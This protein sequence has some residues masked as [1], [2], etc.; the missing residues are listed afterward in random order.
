MNLPLG[1]TLLSL[2]YKASLGWL[3]WTWASNFKRCKL[4]LMK[5]SQ[6]CKPHLKFAGISTVRK[7]VEKVQKK[8]LNTKENAYIFQNWFLWA[9]YI[10][11]PKFPL[12]LPGL[13]ANSWPNNSSPWE[14]YNAFHKKEKLLII[15]G[16][17]EWRPLLTRECSWRHQN[18]LH[19]WPKNG[20]NVYPDHEKIYP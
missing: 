17:E 8:A 12:N 20:L 14:V 6:N 13:H 15:T 3:T 11:A 19:L 2:D 7:N 4:G 10:L 1:V 18:K 16:D 9:N 5:P